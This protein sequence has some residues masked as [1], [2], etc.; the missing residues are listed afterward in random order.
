[1]LFVQE[2]HGDCFCGAMPRLGLEKEEAQNKKSIFGISGPSSCIDLFD[3]RSTKESGI[4]DLRKGR[5]D[6]GKGCC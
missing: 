2:G 4:S 1:M 5:D 6:G 3:D